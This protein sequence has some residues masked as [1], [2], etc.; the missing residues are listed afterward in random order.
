MITLRL[1]EDWYSAALEVDKPVAPWVSHGLVFG[2]GPSSFILCSEALKYGLT[3]AYSQPRNPAVERLM[4]GLGELGDC[5]DSITLLGGAARS[6][7]GIL[8]FQAEVDRLGPMGAVLI[9]P[10]GVADPSDR[11]RRWDR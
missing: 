9:V 1:G 11:R 10:I 4:A 2:W 7:F 3:P 5:P 6:E 8:D